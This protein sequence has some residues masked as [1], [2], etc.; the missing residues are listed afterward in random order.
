MEIKLSGLGIDL[1]YGILIKD[2]RKKLIQKVS[3][4]GCVAAR[5][6]ELPARTVVEICGTFVYLWLLKTNQAKLKYPR[7]RCE[8]LGPQIYQEEPHM[9]TP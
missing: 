2:D 4:C 5:P 7:H 9:N 3:S 8:G 6:V 1:L